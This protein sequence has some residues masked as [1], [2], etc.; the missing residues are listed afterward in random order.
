MT[1]NAA[2]Y[3]DKNEIAKTALKGGGSGSLHVMSMLPRNILAIHITPTVKTMWMMESFFWVIAYLVVTQS[4]NEG[5]ILTHK[6]G[7]YVLDL[8]HI[9]VLG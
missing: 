1:D 9:H 3:L 6:V 7:H 4:D 5:H 2:R 8:Q